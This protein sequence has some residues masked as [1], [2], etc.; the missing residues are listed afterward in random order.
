MKKF[1]LSKIMKRAWELVK[2]AGMT[3]SSGLKKAW[4]EAK[5]MA[6]DIIEKLINNL[7]DMADNDYHINDGMIREVVAKN[8]KKEEKDRTYLSIKCYTLA[9]RLKRE[10]KCGYFDNIKKQYVVSKWD[11]VDAVNKI[12]IGG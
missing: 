7:R 6:E 3:I 9:G 1:N 12:Y 11:D 10:Y 4:E 2:K 5:A 8:W